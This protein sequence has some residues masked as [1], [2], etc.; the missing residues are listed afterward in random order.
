MAH[1]PYK[2]VD[3]LHQVL[4]QDKRPL[5]ILLGAGCPLAIRVVK[6]GQNI[7][8]IP[9]IAGLT[10][11]V[12]AH[13][14][15]A[16]ESPYTELVGHVPTSGKEGP[17][18]EEILS[19][20]R[21]LKQVVGTGEVYGLNADALDEMEAGICTDI[22][23]CVNQELPSKESPYH[24]LVTWIAAAKRAQPVTLFTTNYDLL[25]EQALED[26]SVPYF[27][28]FIGARKPFFDLHAIEEDS[29]PSRW[30]RLWKI[31]GS[32]NWHQDELGVHRGDSSG[33][34]LIYPSHLKYD[35][36]R[37]MPYLAMMDQLRIFLKKPG[38][39]LVTCGYSFS[40]QHIND[41]LLQGLQGNSTAMVF[42]LFF[43]DLDTESPIV[44]TAM[45]R[46]N[47]SLLARNKAVIGRRVADWAAAGPAVKSEP[48]APVEWLPVDPA[49]PDSPEK[50]FF[51]LGDFA[52]F[53]AFVE[54]LALDNRRQDHV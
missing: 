45:S 6:D 46:G 49:G 2:E 19:F 13:L 53:A 24:K 4:E 39:V 5:A 21:L 11:E 30:V 41:I 36:S 25:L 37:R 23:R 42:G 28:G 8:L 7:P 43:S 18:I 17:N 44:G 50:P 22:K 33:S 12:A 31:H 15:A 16:E 20:I 9:D 34:L 29:L 3:L 52:R 10:R 35:Q 48:L 27:D 38:A 26:L 14:G 40:D 54:R 51:R 1:D 47:L 32:V